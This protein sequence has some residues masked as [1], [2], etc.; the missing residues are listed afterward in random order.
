MP[1]GSHL[2][3]LEELT[4]LAVLGLGEN[5]DGGSIRTELA[6]QA[7]RSVSV[8]TIYVT[9]MR[10]EEKGY[11]TSWKGEPSGRRGG[12]ARRMYGVTPEGRRALESVRDVRTA[13]WSGVD[14]EAVS[15]G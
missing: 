1:K 5:A 9:L 13:M 12:K 4:L 14:A 6:E 10:L 15:G 7:N 8:S 2:G 3:D 11:A